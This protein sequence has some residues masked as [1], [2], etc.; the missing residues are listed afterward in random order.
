MASTFKNTVTIVGT[1]EDIDLEIRQYNDK[2]SGEPYNAIVGN[3]TLKA[4][5]QN[6]SLRAFYRDKTAKG[7]NRNY[8]TAL[9]WMEDFDNAK[10]TTYR[11]TSNISS[12]PF[13]GR[14]GQ[15][16]DATQ[17]QGNFL[18]DGAMATQ[19]A[20]FIVDLFITASPIP[21]LDQEGETTGR[22]ILNGEIF[23]F[24]D[25]CFPAKFII[26]SEQAY[27]YFESLDASGSNPILLEVWGKVIN[28]FIRREVTTESAFGE[29]H[30][31]I[32][33]TSR[34]ENIITGAA[35]E[36]KEITDELVNL[37][38]S[39]R[40]AYQVQRAAVEARNSNAAKPSGFGTVDTKTATGAASKNISA[41][42]KFDF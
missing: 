14:D 18:N 4:G 33:Q 9:R 17:I 12:N 6:V 24:R 37:I 30:V 2:V 22:Y 36:P 28:N 29:A 38:K 11:M 34:R 19:K 3:Y 31:D 23:D 16:V 1:L 26:D 41:G 25:T 15:V 42:A 7:P 39:G 8:D 27:N 13:V 32:Q 5:D 35:V 10:G 40:E 21:E 20:E